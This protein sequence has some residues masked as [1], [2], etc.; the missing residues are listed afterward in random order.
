M[1]ETIKGF[2]HGVITVLFASALMIYFTF[3]AIALMIYFIFKGS[4]TDDPMDSD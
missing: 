1:R 4:D 3:R 2:V